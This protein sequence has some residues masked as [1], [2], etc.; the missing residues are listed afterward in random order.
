[1]AAG[2][3]HIDINLCNFGSADTTASGVHTETNNL[4]LGC[5][6]S[7][8]MEESCHEGGAHRWTAGSPCTLA[9]KVAKGLQGIHDMSPIHGV[10]RLVAPGAQLCA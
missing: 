4:S 10:P 2:L 5:Q 1:M 6:N 7:F 9:L 8:Y 3:G